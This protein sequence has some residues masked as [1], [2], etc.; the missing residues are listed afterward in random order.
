ML[1]T[2]A[3]SKDNS[4]ISLEEFNVFATAT[5]KFRVKGLYQYHALELGMD[6]VQE[7]QVDRRTLQ[8]FL[9]AFILFIHSLDWVVVVWFMRA[10]VV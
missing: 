3:F 5:R 1:L 6:A 9:V 2:S 7:N 8:F 10:A 4:D